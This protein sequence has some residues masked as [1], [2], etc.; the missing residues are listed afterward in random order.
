MK[1]LQRRFLI[2]LLMLPRWPTAPNTRLIP[3]AFIQFRISHLGYSWLVGRFNGFNGQFSFDA[4]APETTRITVDIDAASIDTNHNRRRTYRR[5]LRSV[6]R[7]SRRVLWHDHLD[8][9]GFW[10]PDHLWSG[11]GDRRSDVGNRRHLSIST[12][13]RRFRRAAA[14]TAAARS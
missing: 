1:R 11:G 6:G 2:P 9:G 7:P 4:A 13:V 5:G 12:P 8:P 14:P 3:P 10:H